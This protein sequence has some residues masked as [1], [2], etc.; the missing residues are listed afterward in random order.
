MKS[1][2]AGRVS[3]PDMCSSGLESRPESSEPKS[4]SEQ[5]SSSEFPLVLLEP[6]VRIPQPLFQADARPPSQGRGAR[7]IQQLT[8]CTVRLLSIENQPAC[9]TRDPRYGFSQFAMVQS[10][11]VPTLMWDSMGRVWA[12]YTSSGSSITCTA[13]AAISST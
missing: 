13:A 10:L 11:P 3:I 8:G 7:D 1:G 4:F 12:R 9:E 6:S 5:S 2:F